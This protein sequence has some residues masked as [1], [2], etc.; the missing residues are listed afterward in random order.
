[1]DTSISPAVAE[2]LAT[3]EMLHK[4]VIR[5]FMADTVTSSASCANMAITLP[6][7]QA[8]EIIASNKRLNNKQLAQAL[9]VSP[10]SASAM[11]ERLVELDLVERYIPHEDRRT[12]RLQLSDK[13]KRITFAHRQVIEKVISELLERLGETDTRKWIKLSKK[14]RNA[15]AAAAFPQSIP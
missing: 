11:V 9:Q 6:Q 8:L 14:I 3:M 7:A 10:A 1:M 4:H 5:T 15:L 12:V 2:I 13:G